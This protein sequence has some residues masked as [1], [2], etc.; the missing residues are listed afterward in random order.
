MERGIDTAA[1]LDESWTTP[2]LDDGV[3]PYWPE[4]ARIGDLEDF[5]QWLAVKDGPR[6]KLVLTHAIEFEKVHRLVTR[7][8]SRTSE[9][10]R[11]RHLSSPLSSTT[12]AVRSRG[13]GST[14]PAATAEECVGKGRGRGRGAGRKQ[15]TRSRS[16]D[17]T[18]S[19]R[20]PGSTTER[21]KRLAESGGTSGGRARAA[22]LL[23]NGRKSWPPVVVAS[24]ETS[25]NNWRYSR[26]NNIGIAHPPARATGSSRVRVPVPRTAVESTSLEP[27]I[28]NSAIAIDGSPRPSILVAPQPRRAKR[29]WSTFGVGDAK[30]TTGVGGGVKPTHAGDAPASRNG[31]RSGRSAWGMSAAAAVAAAAAGRAA[32]VRQAAAEAARKATVATAASNSG[33]YKKGKGGR[34]GSLP[35]GGAVGEIVPSRSSMAVTGSR[36][37]GARRPPRPEQK[38]IARG[39]SGRRQ[40]AGGGLVRRRLHKESF[41]EFNT[42]TRGWKPGHKGDQHSSP[43]Q[44]GPTPSSV[45]NNGT[46]SGAMSNPSA[47]RPIQS[48]SLCAVPE[49]IDGKGAEVGS[50][51]ESENWLRMRDPVS[52]REFWFDPKTRA[53]EWEGGGAMED[54]PGGMGLGLLS[55]EERERL[56]CKFE[57]RQ[58]RGSRRGAAAT[59]ACAAG[60]GRG[61]GLREQVLLKLTLE[62]DSGGDGAGAVAAAV[63]VRRGAAI[64]AFFAESMRSA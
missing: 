12:P 51:G 53:A 32:G 59:G 63:G 46:K 58:R 31:I 23:S 47:E 35:P 42:S 34:G 6:T 44:A 38:K 1:L 15:P 40:D 2:W 41:A 27:S 14:H 49:E 30:A 29:L 22:M 20:R 11:R 18:T 16:V 48:Q 9:Q 60:G 5:L 25:G 64:G 50:R 62:G 13:G 7:E 61:V 8:L 3:F 33:T 57:R 54:T 21:R 37:G 52:L 39:A 55:K 56:K 4:A 26:K 19:S 10:T 36:N 28:S 24:A 17:G 45:G 43:S